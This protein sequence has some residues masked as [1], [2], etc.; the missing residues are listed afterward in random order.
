VSVGDFSDDKKE[1]KPAAI[2][3]ENRFSPFL[4]ENI[5]K[6]PGALFLTSNLSNYGIW[7]KVNSVPHEKF[8]QLV[9]EDG[10]QRGVSPD[11]KEA[12]LVD[13]KTARENALEAH[14]LKRT[15][16][17]GKQVK[18][19]FINY[20]DLL[21]IYTSRTDDFKRLPK[22][23]NF[24]DQFRSQITCK[25]VA[26]GKHSIYS[27]HRA[28][29]ENIFTKAQ[30]IV[31]VITEDEIIVAL[32][33]TQTYPTD[34]LYLFGVRQGIDAKFLI[35][36]LNSKLFVFIYRLIAIEKGRVLAQ[37]KPTILAQLPIRSI[38]ASIP[39]DKARH[40]KLVAL[41]EQM[42][43]AKQQL[44]GAQSDKEKDFYGN[45]C[46]GLDRQIDDLVYELY[47]LTEDEI[48]IVKGATA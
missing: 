47:G 17:G 15:L 26:E 10:I 39:A 40:D 30:K 14:K 20:P 11:L 24:I 8:E 27:L 46:A 25:E 35:G 3:D 23:R 36:I 38:D 19:F 6:T 12:F 48:T 41:V 2:L 32:D 28:R 31:G 5:Y 44:A 18:R 4:Q 34:G 33:D 1:L 42:L 9:D 22:I 16:T 37:V 43:A 21:L 13:S 45:K 29:E 7:T